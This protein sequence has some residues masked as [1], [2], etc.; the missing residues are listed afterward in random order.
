MPLATT[1]WDIQDHLG[2]AEEQ[3]A[4]LEAAIEVG[5]PSY[6]A[7]ALGDVAKARGISALAEETGLS[8]QGLYK[9]LSAK[10]DPRLSTLIGVLKA[11]GL[12]LRIEAAR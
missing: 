3:C 5:D 1:K 11:L 12:Q 7:V 8:R 6:I 4:Y 9:A 2:T 10:G